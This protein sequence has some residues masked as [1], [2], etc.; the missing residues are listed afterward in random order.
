MKLSLIVILIAGIIIFFTH[1]SEENSTIVCQAGTRNSSESDCLYITNPIFKISEFFSETAETFKKNEIILQQKP[2]PMVNFTAME[3]EISAFVESTI[4]KAKEL[5]SSQDFLV[6][7]IARANVKMAV[8]SLRFE[9]KDELSECKKLPEPEVLQLA[10][11]ETEITSTLIENESIPVK[12]MSTQIETTSTSVKSVPQHV[13]IVSVPV[14]SKST[15]V[16]GEDSLNNDVKKLQKLWNRKPAECIKLANELLAAGHISQDDQAE[17][18]YRKGRSHRIKGEPLSAIEAHRMAAKLAPESGSYL[19]GYAWILSTVK[20]SKYRNQ[21]LALEMAK[22]AVRI[23]QRQSANYLDTLGRTLYILGYSE[24]ALATQK[25]AVQL[26]PKRTSF[27][28]RLKKYEA[29]VLAA[30]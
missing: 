30:D 25:E 7:E 24:E 2:L 18:W 22:E 15:P 10:K 23:S 6:G 11:I 3:E 21:Q 13:E 20:P 27:R 28:R 9:T 29:S 12:M 1:G 16:E 8:S 19:N 17:I 14:K 4:P 26:A 5:Y